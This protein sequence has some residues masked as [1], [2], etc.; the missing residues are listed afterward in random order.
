MNNQINIAYI[1]ENFNW[2]NIYIS[3]NSIISNSTH[4]INI[5]LLY[6]NLENSI[7]DVF[8]RTFKN[9]GNVKF[10]FVK[11]NNNTLLRGS[12]SR[13]L[14]AELCPEIDKILLLVGEPMIVNNDLLDLYN[15]DLQ[16]HVIA[17]SIDLT[18]SLNCPAKTRFNLENI[19]DFIVLLLDFKKFR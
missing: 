13:I 19:Y 11:T 8:S 1:I 15:F 4:N 18:R 10:K 16:G 2:K 17:A 9:F 3:I 14:L 12:W 5:I 7:M 6:D